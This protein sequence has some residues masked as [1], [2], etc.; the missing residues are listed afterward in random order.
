MDIAAIVVGLALV[1]A[2]GWLAYQVRRLHEDLIPALRLA[3]S[4]LARGLASIT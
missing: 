4:P 2:L 1:A 3:N